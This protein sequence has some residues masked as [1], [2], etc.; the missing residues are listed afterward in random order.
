V[1]PYGAAEIRREFERFA[2]YVWPVLSGNAYSRSFLEQHMP[3]Q[4]TM[5]PD[6]FLNTTAPLYGEVEVVRRPLA[7][8]RLHDGNMSYHRSAGDRIGERF[9]KQVALRRSELRVLD[10]HARRRGVSLPH[11][12][13]L[14]YDLPFVNYRLMLKKLGEDYEG[15][16]GDTAFGL[17]RA[18]LLFLIRRPLP[19]RL[20]CSHALWITAL[21]ASPRWLA[22][23]LITLRFNRAQAL[24]PIRHWLA[25]M[26][27]SVRRRDV[28]S[29]PD[30]V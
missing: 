8:Y 5:A 10:E 4:V 17:W 20:K 16:A 24:R 7:S 12:D 2:T 14:D 6:G 29:R 18:G 27:A 9:T 1:E 23:R 11:G 28:A 3:L 22:V 19:V 15:S 25:R 21:L 26:S 13:L 30:G